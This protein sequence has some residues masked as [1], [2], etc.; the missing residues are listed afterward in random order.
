MTKS[1]YLWKSFKT[2]Y[3]HRVNIWISGWNKNET[4]CFLSD[5]AWHAKLAGKLFA[6][7]DISPWPDLTCIELSGSGCWNIF[8]IRDLPLQTQ[9]FSLSVHIMHHRLVHQIHSHHPIIQQVWRWSILKLTSSAPSSLSSEQNNLIPPTHLNFN[10]LFHSSLWSD[11]SMW[12]HFLIVL[13]LRNLDMS[14]TFQHILSITANCD[15][16]LSQ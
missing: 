16:S 4:F 12:E 9:I 2:R 10:L 5:N 6:K 13:S 7:F 14:I 15:Q 8:N 11:L 3:L 1:K